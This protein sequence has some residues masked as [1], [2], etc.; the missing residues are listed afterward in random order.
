MV[1]VQQQLI[2]NI[3]LIAAD[4]NKICSTECGRLEKK[5]LK[6]NEPISIPYLNF[7]SD[8]E[9][10][11]TIIHLDSM[12]F[13]FLFEFRMNGSNVISEELRFTTRQNLIKESY[14]LYNFN[15]LSVNKKTL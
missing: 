10:G 5:C 7:S 1:Q 9:I 12:F 8:G 2:N 13:N 6:D 4:D 3:N 14:F 15:F 11:F